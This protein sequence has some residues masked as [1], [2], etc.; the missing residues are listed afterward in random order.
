MKNLSKYSAKKNARTFRISNQNLN[1]SFRFR[2]TFVWSKVM[3]RPNWSFS[4]SFSY[5]RPTWRHQI[6]MKFLGRTCRDVVQIVLKFEDDIS[7]ARFLIFRKTVKNRRWWFLAVFGG[8]LGPRYWVFRGKHCFSRD[9]SRAGAARQLK[10][11]VFGKKLRDV[12]K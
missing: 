1:I 4:R 5:N 8:S 11:A 10:G 6:F 2:D 7:S 9:R 12:P 3:F